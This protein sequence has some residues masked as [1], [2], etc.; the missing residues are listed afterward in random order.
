MT[1]SETNRPIVKARVTKNQTPLASGL[2]RGEREGST[3]RQHS[4]ILRVAELP[5]IPLI[6]CSWAMAIFGGCSPT[7][8]YAPTGALVP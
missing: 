2:F 1:A 7:K 6:R 5:H 3:P 8:T 4:G